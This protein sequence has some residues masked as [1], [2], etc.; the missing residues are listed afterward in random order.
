MALIVWYNWKMASNIF[1]EIFAWS[2]Q[3][4]PWQNEALRRLFA[5]TQLS[6]SDKDELFN[7]AQMEHGIQ[8]TQ[9]PPIDY[10]LRSTDLPT[11]PAPGQKIILKA[12]RGA[13]NVN[14]LK[15][16]QR[17]VIGGNLTIIYGENAS[18]KSGYA[19]VM[20]KAF[21]ARVVDSVL[22]NVY[23]V[24]PSKSPPSAV[25]EIEEHGAV[26]DELWTDGVPSAD[27]LGRFAV[28]DAK[29]A[30][31]YVSEQN[32]LNF[33]PYGFDIFEGLAG[34]TVEIK[35]RFQ[36][37][38]ASTAPKPDAMRPLIDETSTGRI[39]NAITARSTEV[40]IISKAN[41][42]ENDSLALTAM[43]SEV[44]RLKAGSAQALRDGLAGRR[45]QIA[46]IHSAVSLVAQAVSDSRLE[47]IKTKVRE[48]ATFEVAV[49]TAAKATFGSLDLPGVGGDVWR[50]LL[51]AAATFSTKVAYPEQPFP[52]T[53]L[54]AKCVLCLQPLDENARNRLD[55]FWR[56]IQDN[57]SNKR[58]T[59]KRAV[60]LELEALQ[61]L[62]RSLPPEI[63]MLEETLRSTGSTTFEPTRT[64]YDSMG[65]RIQAVEASIA[66]N[67]WGTIPAMP[68]S[69]V[70]VCDTEL[71][72]IDQAFRG[73]VDDETVSKAIASLTGEIAELNARRRLHENLSHVLD[74]LTALKLSTS[75]ATAASKIATNTITI[76]AAELQTKF[77]TNA[78]KKQVQAELKPIGLARVRA[79]IDKKAD[80]GKVFHKVTVDGVTTAAP[81]SVFSEGERTAI[82]LACFLAELSASDD[83]CG[84][85]FD[86]PVSS[87][88]HRVRESIVSRLVSEAAKRQVIIFTHDLVFYRELAASAERQ[89][90]HWVFQKVEAIG[91]KT[92]ILSDIPP[93][94]ALKIT[95][96]ITRLDA[97]LRAAKVA[98]EEANPEEYR[99]AFR[100]FYALLRSTWERSVEELL[101]NQVVQRLEK[102]VKTL[103]LD[104]VCVDSESVTAVFEGMTRTSNMIE[105]HDHAIA[106]SLSLPTHDQMAQDLTSFKVFV[107]MQ[108]KKSSAAKKQNEHLK[109]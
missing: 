12:V 76:K 56:F 89:Q 88:D 52:A 38:A 13:T 4:A 84:I 9:S 87:L 59:A 36:S 15:A 17:L 50:E 34:V 11:P 5:K 46:A 2:K 74:H 16:D 85:I 49:A 37:L 94:P 81:E 72:A 97:V 66:S 45:R 69:S 22:P 40:E 32:Q 99:S 42:S 107:E 7:L 54:E 92:G 65:T 39:V 109:K 23:S 106:A 79:G 26:R 101:F 96:R 43:E 25:F 83:N 18:G 58:D 78:F 71:S 62:P 20:K 47:E 82:S 75:A 51:L 91:D 29:C 103:S 98:E 93:W 57:V 63:A 64:F 70:E 80:K 6:S 73:I 19:R 100:D 95:Q 104:G 55:R 105:A 53:A 3:L 14:A 1:A 61:R 60:R 30:R 33:V 21:R 102:E 27:C 41:W 86:D 10:T 90:V 67:T 24:T 48:L 108:K 44:A 68:P 31:V 28:F 8:P 77:V 35:Q